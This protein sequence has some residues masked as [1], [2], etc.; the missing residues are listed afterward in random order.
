M[1]IQ[2]PN[3]YPAA[4]PA[5][6]TDWPAVVAACI[7]KGLVVPTGTPSPSRQK[8]PVRVFTIRGLAR[9]CNVNRMMIS[10]AIKNGWLVA[11]SEIA[12]GTGGYLFKA[13][14]V[15]EIRKMFEKL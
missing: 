12:D 1:P 8:K 4:R 13:A 3:A 11:D 2:L 10:R 14:R 5:I 15:P 7:A 9:A 6:G